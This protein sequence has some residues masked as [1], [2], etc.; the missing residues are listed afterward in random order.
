MTKFLRNIIYLDIIQFFTKIMME[1]LKYK[2]Y[3]FLTMNLPKETLSLYSTEK[4]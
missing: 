4:I 1:N 3:I 2:N